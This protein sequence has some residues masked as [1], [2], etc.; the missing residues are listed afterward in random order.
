MTRVV[1]VTRV[2]RLTPPG[3]AGLAVIAVEGENVAKRL[4]RLGLEAPAVGDLALVRPRVAGEVLDEALVWTPAP[5]RVELG[6]HGSPP[7][8]TE[9]LAALGADARPPSETNLEQRAHELLASAPGECAAR[10]LLDQ[11]EGALRKALEAFA[12][13]ALE[14]RE[15]SARYHGARWLLEPAR[16]VLLGPVNAGKSTLFNLLVGERRVTTSHQPGTTRD[17]ILER[18]S[19][20][21]FPVDLVDTAGERELP[22]GGLSAEVERAGQALAHAQAA[23]ADLV[24]WLSPAGGGGALPTTPGPPLVALYTKADRCSARRADWEVD[25]IST[26]QAPDQARAR[27]LEAFVRTL[28][29]SSLAPSPAEPWVPG[30]GVPFEADQLQILRSAAEQP[31]GRTRRAALDGLLG[32]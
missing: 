3:A 8:V 7:L 28:A 23:T 31:A 27:V 19:L 29:P 30:R 17:V 20:G 18:A 26:E 10:I 13:G 4:A 2:R 12:R 14:A 11:A 24:L 22:Q 6:L 15:L 1:R 32:L 9:V 25:W 5:G 16:V 21:P